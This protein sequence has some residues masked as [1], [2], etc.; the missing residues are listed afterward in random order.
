MDTFGLLLACAL[1]GT[2]ISWGR[3]HLHNLLSKRLDPFAARAGCQF[4]VG[5]L[6]L[7]YLGHDVV[8]YRPNL[9]GYTTDVDEAGRFSQ[10][11]AMRITRSRPSAIAISEK[12]IMS[13]CRRTTTFDMIRDSMV[14]LAPK[15]STAS[16]PA[17]HS[18]I[19]STSN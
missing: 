4:M 3:R 17:R 5:M 7:G 8:F 15:G 9:A 12:D 1:P 18:A 16:N 6:A 19:Q 13:A 2:A 10:E 11:E 14:S